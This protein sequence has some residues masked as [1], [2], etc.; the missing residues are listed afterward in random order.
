VTIV[1]CVR[2]PS[3]L[4]CRGVRVA[5]VASGIVGII[6]SAAAAAADE[7]RHIAADQK[8]R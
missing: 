7:T 5:G 6:G 2:C 4:D 1:R 8:L 3:D